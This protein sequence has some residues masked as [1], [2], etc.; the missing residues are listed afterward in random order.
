MWR[1]E[2]YL[3]KGC[4]VT[5]S[6]NRAWGIEFLPQEKEKPHEFKYNNN[7]IR[8]DTP[9]PKQLFQKRQ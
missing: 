7:T 6:T 1:K 2:L 3:Q 4:P 8:M 5:T 9:C